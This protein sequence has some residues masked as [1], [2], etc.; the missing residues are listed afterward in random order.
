MWSIDRID[1]ILKW[2]LA[3][4]SLALV[5]CLSLVNIDLSYLMILLENMVRS[6]LVSSCWEAAWDWELIVQDDTVGSSMLIVVNE[7]SIRT[8]LLW[9]WAQSHGHLP[10]NYIH[11]PFMFL[12]WNRFLLNCPHLPW[13]FDPLVSACCWRNWI[14]RHCCHAWQS[15]RT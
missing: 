1:L 6:L 3:T 2:I 4:C 14:D 7:N 15:A 12:S 10:L 11:G 5:S 13:A 8:G 9:D